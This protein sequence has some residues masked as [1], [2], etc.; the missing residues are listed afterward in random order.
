[1]RKYFVPLVLL[2]GLAASGIAHADEMSQTAA[3]ENSLYG[4]P[5]PFDAAVPSPDQSHWAMATD[6]RIQSESQRAS[7]APVPQ[8]Q[9]KSSKSNDWLDEGIFGA[10]GPE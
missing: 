4:Q 5:N 6:P 2:V 10:Y 7:L 8:A 9:S 1:M 3:Y